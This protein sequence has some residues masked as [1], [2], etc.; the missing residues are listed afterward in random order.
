MNNFP[1]SEEKKNK[2]N[3]MWE[4]YRAKSFKKYKIGKIKKNI[5]FPAQTLTLQ[6]KNYILNKKNFFIGLFRNII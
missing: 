3:Y 6:T 1:F 2:L 5:N 4:R